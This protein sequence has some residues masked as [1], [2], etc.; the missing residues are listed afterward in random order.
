MNQLSI[1]D[2]RRFVSTFVVGMA[3][4]LPGIAQTTFYKVTYEDYQSAIQ[5]G[6]RFGM[7]PFIV[8]NLDD[9]V[10]PVAVSESST[11]SDTTYPLPALQNA[12]DW[13]IASDADMEGV[14]NFYPHQLEGEIDLYLDKPKFGINRYSKVND[15]G[16]IEFWPDFP[17]QT[18]DLAI[19]EDGNCLVTI[20]GEND[21]YSYANGA[22][23]YVGD[24]SNVVMYARSHAKIDFV[25]S[26]NP[27]ND[28]RVQ[29]KFQTDYYYLTITWVVN[30][31]DFPTTSEI[32]SARKE[33]IEWEDGTFE[34]KGVD[35]TQGEHLWIWTTSKDDEF[36]DSKYVWEKTV[37]HGYLDGAIT[38]ENDGDFSVPEGPFEIGEPIR[39]EREPGVSIRYTTDGSEPLS[40]AY[41][42]TT[43][44]Q[45]RVAGTTKDVDMEPLVYTSPMTVKFI[46][47]M[48]GKRE[49]DVKTFTLDTSGTTSIFVIPEANNSGSEYFDLQGHKLQQRPTHPGIYIEHSGDTVKKI[50]IR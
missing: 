9:C 49:S 24:E 45:T 22:F 3:I 33:E 8:V 5:Q 7:M 17:H 13:F 4:I 36:A 39:F 28:G 43:A 46:A 6:G 37:F 34:L 21:C 18:F 12:P 19:N 42:L 26:E 25:D 41:P 20:N 23:K 38:N 1:N 15:M 10:A 48:P 35:I 50:I 47:K 29:L 14:L 31:G 16:F 32:A 40:F 11:V 30:N 2:F 44:E 27:V